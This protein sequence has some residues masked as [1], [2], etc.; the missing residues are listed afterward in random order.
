MKIKYVNNKKIMPMFFNWLI[1]LKNIWYSIEKANVIQQLILFLN[2]T[3]IAKT[4][5]IL[6]F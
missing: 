4:I 5:Y 1:V 6:Y 2:K 3:L